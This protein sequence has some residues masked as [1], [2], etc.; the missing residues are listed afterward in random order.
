MF[1]AYIKKM[2][3]LCRLN[4][5]KRMQM[6]FKRY[7]LIAMMAVAILPVHA[8][9]R[10]HFAYTKVNKIALADMQVYGLSNG[11]LF[12]VNRQS[13]A[14]TEWTKQ[15][16]LH[17]SGIEQ[18]GYDDTSKTLLIAYST[19]KIDLIT[20]NRVIYLS[21]FYNKDMTASKRANN[22][23]FYK[24]RAYLSMEFGI[25][26]FDMRDREFMDTYYI[27]N[28][29]A[30][31]NVVDIVFANDSIYAFSSDKLYC[32]AL[33]DNI[34]DYRFWKHEPLSDRIQR[35]P[36]KGVKYVDNN[37]DIWQAGGTEGIKRHCI[38]GE[39]LA[40]KP[41]GP[42]NN[43]PYR[44]YYDR[45]RLYMLSGGRWSS[46]NNLPGNVMMYEN[47]KWSAIT[48][49]EINAITGKPVKDFMNVAVDAKDRNHF[50]VTSYGTGLYEFNNTTLVNHF[51]PS[52]STLSSA[53][54]KSP[55][56][57]TRCDGA[58]F[59]ADGN[60]LVMAA[61]GDGPTMPIYTKDK[62]WN[63]LDV[64]IDGV[65]RE[66][67][68]PGEIVIDKTNPNLKWIPYCRSEPSIIILDDNG[69]LLDP[70]DDRSISISN[71][72]DQDNNIIAPT[73]FYDLKQDQHGTKWVGTNKGL[74]ILPAEED[75]FETN[76]CRRLRIVGQDGGW[77]TENDQVT[78]ISFDE[79]G[80]VWC[81]TNGVGIYVLS[82]DGS[83]LI[84]HYTSSN[85]IM[86]S[87]AILSLVCDISSNRMYIGTGNGLVSYSNQS[88]QLTVNAT[89]EEQD[90][91]DSGSM[92]RWALHPAYANINQITSSPKEIYALSEGALFAVNRTSEEIT[93]FSKLDGLSA[94][95]IRFI[96]YNDAAKRLVIVYQNGL[97]DLIDDKNH[98]TTMSDL[99]LKGEQS[100]MTINDITSH[101]RYIY[102]AMSFG[103]I[104][105]D[106]VKGE[107]VDTYFIG[108][109][110]SDV[111]V[112]HV[113]IFKDSVFAVS[114]TKLYAGKRQDNLIDFAQ[115]HKSNL[116]IG[117]DIE[118]LAT[119]DNDLYM[120]QD[121]MLY[122]RVNGDWQQ[123]T[124]EMLL[125]IRANGSVLLAGN[126]NNSLVEID[127]SGKVTPL[128]DAF[129]ISDAIVSNGAYWLATNTGLV[130]YNQQSYQRFVPNGPY[131]NFSYR[132][133]FVGDRLMIAQGGRWASQFRR[134]GDVI[135]H[136]YTEK[137]WHYIPAE[138]TM[139]RINSGFFDLMNYAVDPNDINHYYATS[140]G[141][142]LVEFRNN[143]A[144]QLY[145]E[146]N[147][148]LRSSIAG[149]VMRD[150]LRLDGAMFDASGNLWVLNAGE[151]GYPINILTPQGQW[152][153]LDLYVGGHPIYW[154]T[155]GEMFMDRSNGNRKWMFESRGAPGVVLLDDG[156]T[157]FD[158]TDDKVV[159]RND[160]FDQNNAPITPANI[161]CLAQDH[162]GIVW[163]GTP[164]GLFLIE[165][166]DKFFASNRCSRVII[167]RNDGTDL[168]DYL[169]GSE[170]I[171]CIVVDGANRKWIG[172]ENSGLYLVS[173]DGK[174]TIHHF[175]AYNSPLPSSTI[176]SIAIHPLSGEVFIGTAL[177]LASFR[178]DAA[179]PANDYSG[180]YA[181]P[182]PVR[183][184]YDGVITITGLM[185]NTVVNI[186][187]SGGGLV[188]KTRSNGRIAVWDG[189]N[190]QGK[191][192]A[193]GVYTALCNAPD[194]HTVVKIL[195]IR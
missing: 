195:V 41:D 15:T 39:D 83:T 89:S 102:F 11:A 136:N 86:P 65:V 182:N 110:A 77:L 1:F 27:G 117:G 175:T 109:E 168:A 179:E 4:V 64:I 104:V 139:G 18:I 163:V 38:T 124:T 50:F 21:D 99:Y 119:T 5:F 100:E 84:H 28:E 57:Y 78:A 96:T 67:H 36:D 93:Y 189:K 120:L 155:P 43:T 152:H 138:E 184:D 161:L 174:E 173:A 34:V 137:S 59:D 156:G 166:A 71:Y 105:A 125:W 42:L 154:T 70:S 55:D 190:A 176:L 133:Q 22:I 127:P 68:T 37:G 123:V 183:P 45:G 151:R 165:S 60:L 32:A 162:D 129:T 53:V 108:D 188:C 48:Q 147:S 81:G 191:R 92:Y 130:R 12:S 159:K 74:I 115:W 193:T 2:S 8:D 16:G 54:A 52:N 25:L 169:L 135:W 194:G 79:D 24:G 157:P 148:T 121:D 44:L 145:H 69:T 94:S 6:R 3:Y 62:Q 187:D 58:I 103:I 192:V 90:D 10:T 47:G 181:Y 113:A 143:Q 80:N 56:T 167:P 40:Y 128:T 131:S 61:G 141:N 75:Y 134:P 153:G 150:W 116:P 63:G 118:S 23:T 172:T 160:F 98:I 73:A 49:S 33:K 91:A 122:H 180:A 7:V 85:T 186:I 107:I 19:G 76:N 170:R 29:A 20:D 17:S 164:A 101:E 72:I 114:E 35:D 111:N 82:P 30:E 14:I 132:L 146:G 185:D 46:Q 13:E 9:W 95:N 112:E 171:N 26:S 66:I 31:V 88:T 126:E 87:D 51:T 149:D 178:S 142:G 140:F 97:I 177:G 106:V 144:V 158:R